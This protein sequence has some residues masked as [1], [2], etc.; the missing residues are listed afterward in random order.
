MRGMRDGEA[1]Y[2]IEGIQWA[3]ATMPLPCPRC[4]DFHEGQCDPA[5]TAQVKRLV[6]NWKERQGLRWREV[7]DAR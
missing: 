3:G 7:S 2:G 5:E 4:K 1:G 6:D